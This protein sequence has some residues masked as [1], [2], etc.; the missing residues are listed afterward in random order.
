MLDIKYIRENSDIVKKAAENKLIQVD[1]DRL[2]E[3]DLLLR[4]KNQ[5]LDTLREERNKLSSSIPTL[6]DPEKKNTIEYVRTLKDKIS[7]LESE[8]APLKEEF[9]NLMYEVPG[10]PFEEVPIG[11]TDEDNVEIKR[12][13][14]IPTFDFEI[15]DH[16]DLAE[17]LDLVDIPRG[18]KVAGS[19]SYYLKNEAVLLEM[20]LCRYVV[21]KLV[22]KGFTPMTVPTLVKEAP[23]YGTSYFPGGRDQA[24]AVTEDE[25]YLVGTSEVALVSYHS[26]ETFESE[27]E[28]PK[29]YCGYSSCYRRE[30]G[31]YGKDTRGLYRVHQFTKIEQVIMCKADFDEQYRLHDF[32]LNNAEEILQD[33]K[34]PYR[35]VKVCT[36]DM[37][38]GQVRKHD[39]EA[40]MPSR[41]KYSET[42]SCS[43]FNDFQ[44]RR[45]N[46]KY[47]DQDGNTKY[48]YTLNNTAIASPRILIP[49]L[50]LYQ[51]AD[52]SVNIPEVLVP[53]MGGMTKIEKKK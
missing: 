20:A 21:D 26:N 28:L 24:Y 23:M 48:C 2:L 43:S 46:I 11:K 15:K 37:G 51:N 38:I 52:G 40:W 1:I 29:M 10:V 39:I 3:I 33:L 16:V 30:A 34:I 14:K 49:L 53:Y 19:R 17:S 42:H 50:E 45:S 12:V 27:A 13:G 7:A 44:A 25:L 47:K 36:G 32:L 5:E 8:V 31:T 6:V 41:G 22:K 35:V 4:N 9:D 18:V